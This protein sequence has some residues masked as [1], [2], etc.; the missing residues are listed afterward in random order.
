MNS[1]YDLAAWLQLY[2]AKIRSISSR[3]ISLQAL[4]S[5][6]FIFETLRAVIVAPIYSRQLGKK[7][8]LSFEFQKFSTDF[9]NVAFIFLYKCKQLFF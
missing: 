5:L 4:T 6:D 8:N 7:Y 2:F 9:S 3:P 1:I